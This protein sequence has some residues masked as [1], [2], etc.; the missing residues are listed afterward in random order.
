MATV[1]GN[2]NAPVVGTDTRYWDY[3][4]SACYVLFCF[5]WPLLSNY[6]FTVRCTAAA[7]W[8]SL[9]FSIPAAVTTGAAYW[10]YKT[11]RTVTTRGNFEEKP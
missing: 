9:I 8:F 5:I 11:G 10:L 3:G 1:Q 7:P 4:F 2:T 6:S